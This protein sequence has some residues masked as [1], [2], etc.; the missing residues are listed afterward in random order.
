[1]PS[2]SANPFTDGFDTLAQETIKKWKVPGIAFNVIHDDE[3][4]SKAYCLADI[5]NNKPVDV[6]E[7]LYNVGSTTKAQLCAAWAIYINSEA[8]TSKAK[9]DRISWRSPLAQ[10]IPADFTLPDPIQTQQVTLEDLLCHKSG[11]AS[12]DLAYGFEG[13]R[14]PRDV[15]RNLRNLALKSPMRSEWSYCNIGYGVATHALEVVTGKSL[16]EYLRER[17][18]EPLGMTSSFG[19]VGEVEEMGEQ[20]SFELSKPQDITPVSGAGYIVSTASDYTK[21][22]RCLLAGSPPLSQHIVEGLFTPRIPV[23]WKAPFTTPFEGSHVQYALGWFVGFLY[24]YKVLYHTGGSI[25]YGCIVMLVPEFRWAAVMMG[26]EFNT[27]LRVQSLV[28]ELFEISLGLTKDERRAFRTTDEAVGERERMRFPEREAKIK[29]LFP[30]GPFRASIP[31]VLPLAA[32]A[33]TY[34]NAGY[35]LLTITVSDG[36]DFLRCEIADRT[37]PLSIKIQHINAEHWLFEQTNG[38]RQMWKA[39]SRISVNGT[40]EWFGIALDGTSAD[41]LVWFERLKT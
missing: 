22:L 29:A 15:T 13:V 18:W 36:E 11:M 24:G 4:F 2:S 30:G 39:E 28:F 37:W 8:N 35:G 31:Q 12:H 26:N 7:T 40:V 3:E 9:K 6:D 34:F 10:I 16:T 14:T 17:W 38:E 41:H 5:E 25:G 27:G 32:Y 21:W 20:G 23:P 19:G 1:M 33:G